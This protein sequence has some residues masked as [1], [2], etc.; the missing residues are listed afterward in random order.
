MGNK[1]RIGVG[2]ITLHAEL[3]DTLCAKAIADALPV[4]TEPNEWGDEFY[5]EIPVSFR[6]D[7]TATTKVKVGD[8]GYWPPGRALAIFFGPTP[9]SKGPEPVP[10]SEV[11]LVG[12]VIDN[13]ELL[14]QAKGARKIRIE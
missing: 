6:L 10:A 14:R 13:A 8:I 11:N 1:I 4:E 7:S 3:F 5:F 2:S 12:R 9:M